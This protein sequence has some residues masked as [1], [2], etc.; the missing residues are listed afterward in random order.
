[1]SSGEVAAGPPTLAAG[2]AALGAI[3]GRATQAI[4][5]LGVGGTRLALLAARLG[6]GD[7]NAAEPESPAESGS[8][9][10]ERL[11]ARGRGG[12]GFG[13]GIKLCWVHLRSLLSW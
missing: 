5:A 10:F 2:T 11:A 3:G 6:Q 7:P 12:Q 8:N 4:A 9:G 1:M 13:Q